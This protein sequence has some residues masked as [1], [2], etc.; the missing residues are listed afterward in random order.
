ML[1]EG[2]RRCERGTDVVVGY[3]ET[4]GRPMTAAQV[5]ELEV[6][7]RLK[8]EYR[9]ATFEEMDLDAIIARRPEVALV[10]ELA[11]TNVPG[12]RHE[13]RWQDVEEL[14]DAGIT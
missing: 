12:S 11:H 3:V 14:L 6:V 10:D 4:H 1:G 5:G 13:K 2:R 9:G 8:V 7:P